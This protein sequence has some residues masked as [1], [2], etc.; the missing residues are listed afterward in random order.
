MQNSTFP[1]RLAFVQAIRAA[2]PTHP[3]LASCG[4]D[5]LAH[6]AF[7]AIGIG[8]AEV[9]KVHGAGECVG[10]LNGQPLMHWLRRAEDDQRMLDFFVAPHGGMLVGLNMLTFSQDLE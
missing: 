1:P 5:F 9:E 2:S 6:L 8:L 4:N 10:Q 3:A 7:F